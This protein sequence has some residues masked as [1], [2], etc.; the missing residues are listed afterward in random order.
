MARA[1]NEKRAR[2]WGKEG[3]ETPVKEKWSR[4]RQKLRWRDVVQK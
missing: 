4:G 3:Y 1:C 2:E